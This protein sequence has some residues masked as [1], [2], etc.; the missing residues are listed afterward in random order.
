MFVPSSFKQ[1]EGEAYTGESIDIILS[2][3]RK[4]IIL[5]RARELNRIASNASTVCES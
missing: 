5:I 3:Q 1:K 4:E 2:K